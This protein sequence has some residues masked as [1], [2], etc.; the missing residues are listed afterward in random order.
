MVIRF[1]NLMKTLMLHNNTECK[2]LSMLS[3]QQLIFCMYDK[4]SD[5]FYFYYVLKNDLVFN[6]LYYPIKKGNIS[7]NYIFKNISL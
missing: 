6:A 5:Y 3:K 4:D 1:V 7:S 2:K